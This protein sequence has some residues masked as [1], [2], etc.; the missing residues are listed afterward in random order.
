MVGPPGGSGSGLLGNAIRR[1]LIGRSRPWQVVLVVVALGRVLR[2]VSRPRPVV[3]RER[4][5]VGETLEV[6]HLVPVDPL[7]G[8]PA[9]LDA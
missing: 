2:L 3:L 4:L 5:G 1:G 9:S 8:N 6:R 7:A